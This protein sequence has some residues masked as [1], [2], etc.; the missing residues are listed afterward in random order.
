MGQLNAQD[1]QVEEIMNWLRRNYDTDR[2]YTHIDIDTKAVW[3]NLDWGA[4]DTGSSHP[5]GPFF[6]ADRH[7]VIYT[8]N[9]FEKTPLKL[10][11]Q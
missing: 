11:A 8:R 4:D 1:N 9:Q 5:G 10:N 7:T 2:I 6:P 3:L